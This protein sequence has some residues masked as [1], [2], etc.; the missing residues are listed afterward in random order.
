MRIKNCF[1]LVVVLYILFELVT[2][3]TAFADDPPVI[4][5]RSHVVQEVDGRKFYFHA[6]LEGQTLYS[7]A[8]AYNVTVEEIKEANPELE[9]GLRYDQLI[10]IPYREKPEDFV[11]QDFIEHTVKRRETLFGISREYGV[12]VRYILEYNPE[13]RRGINIDQVLRIPVE[14]EE[15][16]PEHKTYEVKRGDTFFSLSRRFNVSVEELIELNPELEDELK[17]GE[18]IRIPHFAEVEP[19]EITDIEEP[20][21]IYVEDDE[22]PEVELWDKSYCQDPDLEKEY[23]VALL[24]PLFLEEIE[25]EFAE[26]RG[27]NDNLEINGDQESNNRKEELILSENHR[28]FAFL[29]FYQGMLIALDSLK[30]IGA[31]ITLHVHDVCQDVDKAEKF[32]NEPGFEDMDLIIGPFF[33]SSLELVAKNAEEHD[34]SVVSP[35]LQDRNQLNFASNIFQFTPSLLTQLRD[36]SEY[37]S[38]EYPTQNI[39]LVHNNQPQVTQIISDF[40]SNLNEQL[41]KRKVVA[42]S[43]NLAKI[44]GYY[45]EQSL[46]GER[47]NSNVRVFDDSLHEYFQPPAGQA[48]KYSSDEVLQAYITQEHVTEVVL[49]RDSISGLKEKLSEYNNNILV[50]LIGGEPEVS[51]YLREMTLLSDTFDIKVFG[52]PQWK[53]YKNIEIDHLLESKV[54]IISPEFPD[55]SNDNVR[56][57]VLKYRKRFNDEPRQYAFKGVKAGYYFI[58]AL[59]TYGRDFHKCIHSLNLQRDHDSI[60]FTKTAGKNNGWENQRTT[61]FKYEDYKVIDVRAAASDDEP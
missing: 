22:A 26:Q 39:I 13:A 29:D 2:F 42:D 5:N 4:I 60:I 36:L 43:L 50:S 31:D 53:N 32:I 38:T 49:A 23:N 46:V 48:A 51:N 20:E 35:L 52:V 41:G 45:L 25:E 6:V 47:S 18:T 30:K 3:N 14:V 37:I 15:E 58:N 59:N 61:I 54:H 19:E 40:N 12:E 8:R 1:F 57:F 17:A 56:D 27:Y 28:S 21:I 10:K 34:I 9:H 44:N 55:Y 24:M 16:M 7:I 11:E 33:P